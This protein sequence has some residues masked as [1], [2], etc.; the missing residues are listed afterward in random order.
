L[1]VWRPASFSGY[2]MP[3]P[4]MSRAT[5]PWGLL[6]VAWGLVAAV[7]AALVVRRATRPPPASV[8]DRAPGRPT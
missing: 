2:V 3:V 4:T 6:P 8:I 5:P 7:A 1:A